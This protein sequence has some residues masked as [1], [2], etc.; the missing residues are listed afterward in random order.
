M[1]PAADQFYGERSGTVRDPFGH[2]WNIGHEIEKVTPEEMQRRYDAMI[3][4]RR[5]GLRNRTRKPQADMPK[6]WCIS[7]R[8]STR[9]SR[10]S[11]PTR[12]SGGCSGS[13]AKRP[14][15][16]AASKIG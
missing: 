15:T 16:A 12:C 13:C 10:P 2:E 3:E 8:L 7:V 11:T 5:R 6:R 1:R 4:E 9:F 14:R